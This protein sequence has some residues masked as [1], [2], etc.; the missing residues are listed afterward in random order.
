MLFQFKYFLTL[1]KYENMRQAASELYISQPALT[2]YVKRFENE[3]NIQLI[4]K[5]GRNI[6]LTPDAKLL[7]PYMEAITQSYDEMMKLAKA[8][9]NLTEKRLYIGT[10]MRH[11]LL[12]VDEYLTKYPDRKI[13]LK[14]YYLISDLEAALLQHEIDF[15]L[16]TPALKG[17][18]I[19]SK[20]L[21]NEQFGLL[22]RK[23][24][25]FASKESV[26]L[27]EIS[28]RKTFLF[29]KGYPFNASLERAFKEEGCSLP[30]ADLVADNATLELALLSDVGCDHVLINPIS[31]CKE[32]AEANNALMY[33][34]VSGSQSFR[35]IGVSWLEKNPPGIEGQHFIEFLSTFYQKEKY[36]VAK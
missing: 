32:I 17:K 10:V 9:S 13:Q 18:G 33:V 35:E 26:S 11:T 23:D 1:A 15:A 19:H 24:D 12:T 6:R 4:E 27:Q 7:L 34:P 36:S 14:Q 2:S 16:G 21:I 5:T 28:L 25:P 8:L 29:P 22:M 30:E 20:M 31:R 3:L